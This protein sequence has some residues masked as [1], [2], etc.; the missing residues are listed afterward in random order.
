MLY[1]RRPHVVPH[2]LHC[3]IE[4]LYHRSLD[5]IFTRLADAANDI[6]PRR[7]SNRRTIIVTRH[8]SHVHGGPAAPDIRERPGVEN[9][10]PS[11]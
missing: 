9:N 1:R 8:S 5:I 2:V 3:N 10:D 6:P 4:E 11:K 7:A